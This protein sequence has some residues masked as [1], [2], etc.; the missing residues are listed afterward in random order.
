M[1]SDPRDFNGFAI[2][3]LG[4]LCPPGYSPDK[5]PAP[6]KKPRKQITRRKPGRQSAGGEA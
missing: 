6:K 4:E 3:T 5:P 2:R 1:R